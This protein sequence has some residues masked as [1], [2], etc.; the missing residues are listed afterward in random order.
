MFGGGV[1]DIFA[2]KK[3]GVLCWLLFSE[4]FGFNSIGKIVSRDEKGE[5]HI[6]TRCLPALYGVQLSP[7]NRVK[8]HIHGYMDTGV[9]I[10]WQIQGT[11]E[12]LADSGHQALYRGPRKCKCI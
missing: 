3:S 7:V 9:C 1:V 5:L 10:P 11:L 8:D 12:T 4:S 2:M 6:E